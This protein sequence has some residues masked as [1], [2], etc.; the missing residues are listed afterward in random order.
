MNDSFF[1]CA[2]DDTADYQVLLQYFLQ[3]GCPQCDLSLFTDGQSLLDALARFD[4]LPDLILLDLH[5]RPVDGQH[6]LLALKQQP[7][8]QAIP[9]VMMSALATQE[10]IRACYKAG[11]NAFIQ[12]S[13]D[14]DVFKRQLEATC[15]YWLVLSE[16][17]NSEVGS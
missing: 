7:A 14:F 15:Y 16:R 10:E 5:M 8:Y 3:Q 6:T 1:V 11:A 12:K 13:L 17:P 9:V 2:V 4:Q